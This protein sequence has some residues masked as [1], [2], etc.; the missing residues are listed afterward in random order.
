MID[1]IFSF[2]LT[3]AGLYVL[4]HTRFKS[5][6]VDKPNERSLHSH[7][8]PR[9]GG[10]AIMT[11]VLITWLFNGVSIEWLLLPL[12]LIAISLIDDIG[13]LKARWR[14]LAQI[15]VCA[16]FLAIYPQNLALW[17]MPL[18][19]LA[20][21]WMVNLYNFMDGSDG[22]AGGMAAFGFGTY[23]V[24]AY[25]AG[26]PDLGVLCLAIVGA[27]VAFLL[28]NFHPAKIFMGDAGS[29]PLGFLAAAFGIY[30]WQQGIWPG[31]FPF[32]V[33]SPFIVDASVTLLRRLLRREKIWEAHK[34]HYY[35]RLV[36]MSWGHRKTA[37]VEYGVM[38]AVGI[39]S[40]IAWC[41]DGVLA[42]AVIATWCLTYTVLM[43]VIDRV[44]A[45]QTEIL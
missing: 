44:W 26:S 28:F 18:I 5:L 37:L 32:L 43:V 9:T 15:I 17:V 6:A 14:F 1:G 45:R 38:L 40:I 23:A 8:I 20:M 13:G 27:S 39:S 41:Y 10:L 7:I 2:F 22:L 11:A 16:V 19:L 12:T 35:Q 34:S 30:G 31:W 33:F 42:I 25:L 21:V 29:I 3:Q 4:L 24:T 36:Q